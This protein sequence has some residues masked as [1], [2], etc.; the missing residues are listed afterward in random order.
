MNPADIR[1]TDILRGLTSLCAHPG[2]GTGPAGYFVWLEG[3]VEVTSSRRIPETTFFVITIS[4]PN[5]NTPVH[6]RVSQL[7]FQTLF[8]LDLV[9]A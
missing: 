9:N 6:H 2:S 3:F 1:Y 7:A 5:L 8:V 4:S